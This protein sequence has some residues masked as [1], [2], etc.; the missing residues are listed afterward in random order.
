M[1]TVKIEKKVDVIIRSIEKSM[2]EGKRDKW[3]KQT[4]QSF[5]ENIKF[6][7]EVKASDYNRPFEIEI[8]IEWKRSRT[9]GSN[10]TGKMW[11]ADCGFIEGR[12]IGGCGYDKQSTCVAQLLNKD[13]RLRARMIAKGRKKLPYGAGY[14]KLPYFEGGVGIECHRRIIEMLGGKWIHKST[15]NSDWISISFK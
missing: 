15:N 14:G 7:E 11:G 1:R 4:M 5:K 9:W 3:S 2:L 10:P 13:R 6:L 12:S 8:A